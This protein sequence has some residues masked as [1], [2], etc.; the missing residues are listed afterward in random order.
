MIA[1]VP[2]NEIASEAVI[3]RTT[4]EDVAIRRDCAVQ[5]TKGRGYV[6]PRRIASV[7]PTS[8]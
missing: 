7:V 2:S 3:A 8:Q 5:F 6:L 1:S 4:Q